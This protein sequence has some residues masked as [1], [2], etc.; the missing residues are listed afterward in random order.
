MILGGDEIGRTQEGNN[1]AYCQDNEISW[2]D[3]EKVDHH[4]LEFTRR[5]IK[6]RKNHIAFRSFS[7]FQGRPLRGTEI[8]DIYW[9]TSEGNE[10]QEQDWQQGLVKNLG[11]FLHGKAVPGI[12][13]RGDPIEDH[14]FYLLF[15]T[16]EIP[17]VFKIAKFDENFRWQ[18]VLDT[19]SFE[20]IQDD[21]IYQAGAKIEVIGR[22][23]VVLMSETP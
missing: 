19:A 22:S 7:W 14:S 17:I 18:K 1:N 15:N 21:Q 4:F 11:I 20:S 5:L 23:L 13:P 8:K 3:W 6:F 16:L 12:S 10:M 2:F 9:L